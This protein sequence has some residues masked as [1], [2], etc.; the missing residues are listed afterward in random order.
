MNLVFLGPLGAGK[1]TQAQMLREREGIPQISTGDMLRQAMVEETDLGRKARSF[2]DRGEL[3]PDDVMIG[4]IDERLRQPDTR[5]GFVLDG[6]PRTLAQAEALDRVLRAEGRTLDAVV[7]YKVSDET[8]ISRLSGRRVCRKAAHIFHLDSHPPRVSGRCDVDGSE[9]FQRE[10]DK[11]DTVRH[12]LEV[13]HQQTEPLV[14]FYR[15]RGI[16]EAID[17]EADIDV[18]HE[19]LRRILSE[20]VETH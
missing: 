15:S 20:R 5:R 2:V 14:E 1:G 6:F 11:E 18:V 10:D 3:V 9:L 13:Y 4:L 19:R 12:R 7:Y 16:L 8:I 17:A